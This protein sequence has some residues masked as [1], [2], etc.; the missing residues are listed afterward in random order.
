MSYCRSPRQSV[1]KEPAKAV[2]SFEKN[3]SQNVL[4]LS[5]SGIDDEAL[6]YLIQKA[7]LSHTPFEI[8]LS[9]NR[10]SQSCLVKL[11]PFMVKVQTVN[12]AST[13]LNEGC[14]DHLVKIKG[15]RRLEE[16]NLLDNNI[17]LHKNRQKIELLK[18]IGIKIICH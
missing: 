18:Q 7:F 4:N 1:N 5:N 6:L 10:L 2:A 3:M 13:G 15:A 16:I 9:K 12:L 14:L 11:L 8:N 17:S